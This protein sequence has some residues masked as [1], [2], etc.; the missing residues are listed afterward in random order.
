MIKERKIQLSYIESHLV[1]FKIIDST[2]LNRF[3]QSTQQLQT[4]N[5]KNSTLEYPQQDITHKR[6]SNLSTI[7]HTR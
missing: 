7:D 3:I 2:I 6:I 4:Q 1:K 5:N